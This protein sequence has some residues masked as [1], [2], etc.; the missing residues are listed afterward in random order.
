MRLRIIVLLALTFTLQA[1]VPAA[2]VVGATAGGAV[3]YDNRGMKTI[4]Q[5]NKTAL[6]AQD[7]IN[8]DPQLNNKQTHI[9][10]TTFNGILLLVGQAPT[11]EQR[12]RAYEIAMSMKNVKRVYNQITIAQPIPM[13]T[14]SHDTWITTKVKTM[15]LAEPGLRSTQIKVLTE[16]G[17]VYLMG[18]VSHTQGNLAAKVAS[19]ASGVKK[20]VKLFEYTN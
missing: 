12:Q 9:S 15:M 10:V 16:D 20:V 2:F 17:V 7:K 19:K 8:A 4:M 3:V 13:S 5:D 11:P 18:V 1:C 6:T 14:R